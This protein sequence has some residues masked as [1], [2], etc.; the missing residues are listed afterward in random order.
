M[1]EPSVSGDRLI[2]VK[3]ALPAIDPIVPAAAWSLSDEGRDQCRGLARSLAPYATGAA[4]VASEEPKARETAHLVGDILD[5]PVE[6][7]PDLH[8][9][10]RSGVPFLGDRAW[11][12][13]IDRFFSEPDA[14][15]F[16][17]ETAN[18]ATSRFVR[19]VDGIVAERPDRTV[20]VVA[21]GTVISLYVAAKTRQSAAALWRR[22][23][24]PSFVVLARPRLDLIAVVEQ[25][26]DA[27]VAA[28][29]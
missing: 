11:Q 9:H 8:E 29:D 10:D 21:H 19:A 2:L 14:L 5:L 4:L 16:G 20:I 15:V 28:E 27:P 24:L 6:T 25:V 12:A 17:R 13:A 22:L 26:D 3:H 18:G 23:G 7:R 1:T